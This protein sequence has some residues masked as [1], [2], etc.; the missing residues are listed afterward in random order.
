[1]SD[2]RYR[3]NIEELP[4]GRFRARIIDGVTKQRHEV[5][6]YETRAVAELKCTEKIAELKLLVS[7]SAIPGQTPE[8]A[9][10]HI[11]DFHVGKKETDERTFPERM[12]RI[13]ERLVELRDRIFGKHDIHRLVVAMTG[14]MVDGQGVY[15][16]QAYNQSI[17][18]ARQQSVVCGDVLAELFGSLRGV[19]G[20]VEI[21]AVPGNHGV[22][23]F[24]ADGQNWD[25]AA[26]D[27]IADKLAGRVRLTYHP[28]DPWLLSY[29]IT[30]TWRAMLYHGHKLGKTQT[31]VHKRMAQWATTQQFAGYTY[32]LS[33]HLHTMEYYELNSKRF[34]RTGTMLTDDPY[35]REFGYESA[36]RSWL[37]L[38]HPR[39]PV[40]AMAQLDMT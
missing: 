10:W 6:R 19:Y 40:T 21:A 14:D 5:G 32:L 26:Y 34:F 18:D 3:S 20:E 8:V 11:G 2:E 16:S 29:P 27:R 15:P 35:A 1:M 22:A 13:R 30:P 24:A 36:T 23:K 17:G 31:S 12:K 28:A 37:F 25:I 39:R 38:A 4:D 33:G 9:V 7:D